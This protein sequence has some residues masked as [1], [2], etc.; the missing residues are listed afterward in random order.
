MNTYGPVLGR[1]T[2]NDSR[3]L[4]RNEW[5]EIVGFRFRGT[6]GEQIAVRYA[7]TV[8]KSRGGIRFERTSNNDARPVWLSA[9]RFHI[10]LNEGNA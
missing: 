1:A 8:K 6:P 10:R 2:P 9:S 4:N 5:Y 7:G 3:G